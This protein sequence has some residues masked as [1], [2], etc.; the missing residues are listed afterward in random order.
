MAKE[1]LNGAPSKFR[2]SCGKCG[3]EFTYEL[4]DVITTMFGP[5]TTCP[6]CGEWCAHYPPPRLGRRWP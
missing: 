3:C 4:N 2:A 6:S 5:K 1:I